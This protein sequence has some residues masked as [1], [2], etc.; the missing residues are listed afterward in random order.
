MEVAFLDSLATDKGFNLLHDVN[1]AKQLH[2]DIAHN[3]A[4][5]VVDMAKY[6]NAW[7][8]E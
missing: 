5:V 7:N 3:K 8:K 6:C 2:E 4:E 1:M